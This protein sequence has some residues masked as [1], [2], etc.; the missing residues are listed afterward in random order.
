VSQLLRL[1]LGAG[2]EARLHPEYVNIDFVAAPG[3]DVVHNVMEFPWPFEDGSAEEIRAIDLIEHLPV[4]TRDYEPTLIKFAEEAHRI[5]APGGLLYIQ[6]PH[7][8]SKNLWID[9]SHVRGFDERSFD[10]FDEATD[11][12]R[13]YGYYSAARFSV[14]AVRTENDNVQFTM[15]KQ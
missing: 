8:Q 14:A 11:L 13:D 12:G 15:R 7:W 1:N 6:T 4:S 3:I 9:L 10:Y 5:L 2:S